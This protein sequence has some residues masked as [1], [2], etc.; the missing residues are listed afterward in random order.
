MIAGGEVRFEGRRLNGLAP[1]Q[2]CREGIAY[3]PEGQRVWPNMTVEENLLMG[4]YTRRDRDGVA[5]DIE[6][7]YQVFHRL[8]SLSGR[9][10]CDLSGGERQMVALGRALMLRPRCLLVDEPTLGLAPGIADEILGM[11]VLL[12]REHQMGVALVEQNAIKALGVADRV[13]VMQLGE[14]VLDRP[15]CGV[16]WGRDIEP[17]LLGD[18]GSA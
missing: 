9:K 17:L 2:V 3:V 1:H 8:R 6:K 7:V 12:E 18:V 5:R 15:T 14:V 11:V 4:A 16:L 13:I 10:A